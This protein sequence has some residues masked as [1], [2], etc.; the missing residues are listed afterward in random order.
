[1]AGE[2]D[3]NRVEPDRPEPDAPGTGP[4]W[5]RKDLRSPRTPPGLEWRLWRR[6]PQV[7]LAGTVVP[8]AALVLAH[9]WL[10]GDS[11][12]AERAR[13]LQ[14][15]DYVVIGLIGLHW[16]LLIT[17]AIGCVIVMIMKGPRYSADSY[18][19]PHRDRPDA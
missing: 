13:Q 11:A 12:S 6:L 17:V 10:G 9:L 2:T 3:P 8:L 7:A 16:I 15:A 18:P 1:M 4:R 5:L 19:V 14:L